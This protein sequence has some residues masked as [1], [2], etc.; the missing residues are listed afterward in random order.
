[1][2][3][4]EALLG[5]YELRERLGS[6]GMA[7]VRRAWDRQLERFV[8]IKLFASGTA[9]D[10]AR[11]RTE[12]SILARLSH[13]H[14]VALYDAHLAGEGDGTPSF[15]VMELVAGPDLATRLESGPLPA[16]EAAEVA[17]GIAEALVAVHAA[18]MVHRDLKPANILLGDPVVPGGP[19]VLKLADFGIAHLVGSERLTTAGTV[20]G[21][22]GYLS[23]EQVGGGEPGPGA[24]IYSLGLVVLETLTGVREFRGTPIEAVAARLVRDPR[25]PVSLPEDWRGLLHAMTARDPAARPSAFDVAVMARAIAPQLAGWEAPLAGEAAAVGEIG[26]TVAMTAA[27]REAEPRP[28]RRR[29]LLSAAIAGGAVA[30]VATALGLGSMAAPAE[31]P[32]SV[33]TSPRPVPTVTAPPAGIERASDQTRTGQIA[34]QSG[35]GA[36]QPGQPAQQTQPAPPA[37]PAAP[38]PVNPNKGPGNNNGNGNGSGKSGK[39]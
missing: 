36:V 4:D 3:E 22:A 12:A 31:R 27:V 30:V 20:I 13:P 5:R 1:M 25:I 7:T 32:Q 14:L 11:R 39:G 17:I 38:A 37:P 29:R 9:V 34:D 19:P 26:P 8:A 15:L 2:D 10:D 33:P 35:A 23:P 6:G 16:E 21:T 18:G 28:A 24:D